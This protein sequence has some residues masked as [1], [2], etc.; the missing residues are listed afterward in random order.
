M[1]QLA[2]RIRVLHVDDEPAFGDLTVEFLERQDD[3]FVVTTMTSA[4]ETL[5]YLADND[6]DC[7]VSD[8]DMPGKNGVELLRAVREEYPDLPF[9]LFTGKGSEE[10]ASEAISAGVTDY[11]QKSGGADQYALLANRMS[12]AVERHAA[13]REIDWHRAI[14]RNM[15][16]G[17][18]VLDAE[19]VI[20]FVKFRIPELESVSEENWTGRSL[21]Y[22]AET[23]NLSWTEVTWIQ[24]AVDRILSGETDEVRI[25]LEPA[26]PEL[27][28]VIEL[29][30]SPLEL[31]SDEQLVL[32]TTRDITQRKRHER[33]L[34]RFETM[35]EA[36]D[37]AAFI[38][39]EDRTLDY[40]N[41]AAL[42]NIGASFE[43]VEG[44][45]IRSLA[46]EY[47]ADEG[48]S[49]RFVRALERAFD[50]DDRPDVSERVEMTLDADGRNPVFEYQLSP[51]VEDGAVRAV[52]V[53]SR[54]ITDRMA[55]ERELERQ[56]DRL[57]EFASVVSHD[58]RNPLQVARTRLALA[59]EECDSEHLDDAVDAIDR[60]QALI[61]DLLT[62]AQEGEGVTDLEPVELGDVVE[63]CWGNVETAGATLVADVDRTVSADRGRLQQLLENLFRN[64]VEHGPDDVTVTV[65]IL[66]DGF[67]VADDGPGIP[68]S[69]R[70]TVFDAGY[71]TTSGTGF[72][73]VIVETIAT[74]HGWDV[75]VTESDDGG[76]RVEL[77]GVEFVE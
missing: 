77:T 36:T 25:E 40:A 7:V 52:V 54:E 67:Y 68:E 18:Y 70:E 69:E 20:R 33:R 65:G 29:R 23:D 58:L 48:G 62:L 57:E 66:A 64:A 37:E 61:D 26:F 56:N 6:V 71:S 2:D 74:A 50:A 30:L 76:M 24:E 15:G 73:L 45:S 49:E 8:Y 34:E 22:L 9:I 4:S 14:L 63:R 11:L 59:D 72:G 55:Y 42:N 17:V 21:S 10:V 16:E 41:E 44:R 38:V 12:N 39:D 53:M 1:S 13:E 43:A 32:G 19:Y 3:R 47:V 35:V 46:D 31:D 51:I 60:S 28:N 27:T 75:R 5:D